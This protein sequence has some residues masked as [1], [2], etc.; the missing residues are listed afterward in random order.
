MNAMAD[1]SNS[2]RTRK[3]QR[4]RSATS[5]HGNANTK[6]D[7]DG[8]EEGGSPPTERRAPEQHPS[9]PAKNNARPETNEFAALGLAHAGQSLWRS[10]VDDYDLERHEELL[11]L[12]ACRTVDMLEEL[13]TCVSR[14]GV[15]RDGKAHPG[16][17]EMR[18]QRIALAR[19]LAALRLPAGE[20]GA[21]GTPARRP[22]RRGG[23]RGVYGIRG[24]VS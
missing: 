1:K 8:R 10:I 2:D 15:M 23:A 13:E 19:L 21:L 4:P 5:R 14:D 24:A 7:R 11:L 6:A 17:V 3:A 12:Q 20:E 22:Q 16:V 18:Q 9:P